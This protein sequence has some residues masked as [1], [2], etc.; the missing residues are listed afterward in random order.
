MHGAA[1]EGEIKL[2]LAHEWLWVQRRFAP[3]HVQVVTVEGDVD[4]PEIDLDAAELL[5]QAAEAVRERDA[6]CVDADE[7]DVLELGIRLDDLVGDAVKRATERVCVEKDPLGGGR[8]C[9]GHL[10]TPFRPHRT[11][12]KQCWS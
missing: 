1:L 12:L 2:R 5:D 3:A 4:R 7:R 11:G 6:A 10:W 9:S 8:V